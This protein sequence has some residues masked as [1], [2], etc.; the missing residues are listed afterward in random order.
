M[1]LLVLRFFLVSHSLLCKDNPFCL[2]INLRGFLHTLYVNSIRQTFMKCGRERGKPILTIFSP[3]PPMAP[4]CLLYSPT[5]PSFKIEWMPHWKQI[6]FIRNVKARPF[7][8][9]KYLFSLNRIITAEL[10]STCM[11]QLG[12]NISEKWNSN[13]SILPQVTTTLCKNFQ[14]NYFQFKRP[15]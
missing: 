8:L 10:V 3:P 7:C 6:S 11:V 1:V 2:W 14:Q 15:I 9:L 5:P 13:L 12:K 4:T